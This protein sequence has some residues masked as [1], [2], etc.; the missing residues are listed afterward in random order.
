MGTLTGW[1]KR[2]FMPDKQKEK[3]VYHCNICNIDLDYK[4]MENHWI[5]KKST[6]CPEHD[7]VKIECHFCSNWFNSIDSMLFV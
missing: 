7:R 1:D 6:K 5:E 4:A 2:K 3:K